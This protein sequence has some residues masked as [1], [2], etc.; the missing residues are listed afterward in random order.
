LGQSPA[1]AALLCPNA[2]VQPDTT[3]TV[4]VLLTPKDGWHTYWINPGESGL[5][6]KIKWELPHGFKVG[7]LQWP[8]PHP[9]ET[10][11]IIGLGN[12]GPVLLT[13]SITAPSKI[14]DDTVTLKAH[15]TWL[16]CKEACI[17]GRAKLNLVLP[18]KNTT[19]KTN[20]KTQKLFQMTLDQLPQP[21]MITADQ[22]HI[23]AGKLSLTLPGFHLPHAVFYASN[24][25]LLD[26][27]AKQ[28]IKTS[29][30]PKQTTLTTAL[31]MYAP[32]T[33]PQLAGV[34]IANPH[35]KTSKAYALDVQLQ[36]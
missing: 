5:P 20:P 4:G 29:N 25:S 9:F 32:K 14:T 26:S 19:P 12:D 24:E 8:T 33:I 15:V 35:D 13:V 28:I 23:A 17:P 16:V 34:L 3:F 2:S 27:G 30:S 6:T 18:I 21:L 36:R 31:S 1:T 22:V 10:G 11:G 7:P